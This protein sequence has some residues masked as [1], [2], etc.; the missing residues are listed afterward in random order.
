MV[1]MNDSHYLVCFY[2]LSVEITEE[3]NQNSYKKINFKEVVVA[4]F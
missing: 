4:L 1:I 3:K 2:V